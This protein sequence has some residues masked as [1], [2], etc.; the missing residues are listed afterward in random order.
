MLEQKHGPINIITVTEIN[1][2]L[3][4]LLIINEIVNS[5]LQIIKAK[6]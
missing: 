5:R 3:K 2:L 6:L 1:F 4:C